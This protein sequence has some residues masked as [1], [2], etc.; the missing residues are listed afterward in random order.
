MNQDNTRISRRGL[1]GAAC[2]LAGSGLLLPGAAGPARAAIP[3]APPRAIAFENLHTGERLDLTYWKGGAPIAPAMR[4]I[5]HLFRDHRANAVH[6]I[7]PELIDLLHDL[8]LALESPAPI[9][10]ISGYRSPGTNAKL[11]QASSGVASGS[12]HMRGMAVDIRVPGRAL[13]AVRDAA[14][15]LGRGG[16]GFYPR[17]DFVHLDIGRVRRW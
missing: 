9:Q 16:V 3:P 11:A 12:L 1:L 4:R 7:A 2:A 14:L 5:E 6:G 8:R 17:S 15:A 10:I 13:T